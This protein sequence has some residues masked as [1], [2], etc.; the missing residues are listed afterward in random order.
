MLMDGAVS[1]VVYDS[2]SPEHGAVASLT[3]TLALTTLSEAAG[4]QGH[5]THTLSTQ[6]RSSSQIHHDLSKYLLK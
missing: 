4:S 5:H 6:Q 2:R 3:L 1:A